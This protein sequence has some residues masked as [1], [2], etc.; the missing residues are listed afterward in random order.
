MPHLNYSG[1]KSVTL[2][3]DAQDDVTVP[4]K[5]NIFPFSSEGDTVLLQVER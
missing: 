5:R 1:R 3:L 4:L 2:C